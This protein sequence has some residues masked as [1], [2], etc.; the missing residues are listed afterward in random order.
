MFNRPPWSIAKTG[1]NPTSPTVSTLATNQ[2]DVPVHGAE[3]RAYFKSW[4][5]A[6]QNATSA[7]PSVRITSEVLEITE[8]FVW[9]ACGD[10]DRVVTG[11]VAACFSES[12]DES[13]NPLVTVTV[14]VAEGVSGAVIETA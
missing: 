6:S 2:V 8:L 13:R 3:Q 9:I 11:T 14:N 10:H 1:E 12:P 5:V 4:F 7:D